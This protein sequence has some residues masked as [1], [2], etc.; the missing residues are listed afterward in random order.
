MVWKLRIPMMLFVF[1]F[2]SGIHQYFPKIIIF[3]ENDI[4]RSIQYICTLGLIL[5]L[6]EIT[7]INEK[8]VNFTLG[9]AL[10]I[11]G[12]LSDYFTSAV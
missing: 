10:I 7:G 3:Q 6:L 5:Y 11:A 12:F 4:L 8:K 2:I 1:G 9:I